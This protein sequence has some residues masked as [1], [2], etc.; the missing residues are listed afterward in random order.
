[1]LHG[2]FKNFKLVPWKIF[3]IINFSIVYLITITT[4]KNNLFHK[5]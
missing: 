5:A 3:A 1:M 4:T 2:Q